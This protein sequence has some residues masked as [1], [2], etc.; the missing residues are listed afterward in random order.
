MRASMQKHHGSEKWAGTEA[1]TAV[2][3]RFILR[4]WRPTPWR[5]SPRVC[6]S[7]S[8]AWRCWG[9]ADRS[10]RAAASAA[11]STGTLRGQESSALHGAANCGRARDRVERRRCTDDRWQRIARA[12]GSSGSDEF[13]KARKEADQ[14]NGSKQAQPAGICR[15]GLHLSGFRTSKQIRLREAARQNG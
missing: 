5:C 4:I 3:S 10:A 12:I 7:P 8:T 2:S 9:P 6:D 13:K 11:E 15:A 14:Q 1:S